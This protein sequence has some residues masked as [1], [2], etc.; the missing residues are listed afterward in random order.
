MFLRSEFS[1][2]TRG[3]GLMTVASSAESP[4]HAI[5][6]PM[7]SRMKAI[8]RRIPCAVDGGMILVILGA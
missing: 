1:R 2:Q 5:Y 3:H 4:F 6:T 8:K 7:Q